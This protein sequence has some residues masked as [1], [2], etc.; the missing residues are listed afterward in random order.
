MVKGNVNTQSLRAYVREREEYKEEIPP[1]A[2]R[3]IIKTEMYRARVK[4]KA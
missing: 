4:A 3:W 1:E 2:A